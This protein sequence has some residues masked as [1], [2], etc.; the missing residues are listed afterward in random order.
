MCVI[1]RILTQTTHTNRSSLLG[2]IVVV[3]LG[4]FFF[5]WGK[6]DQRGAHFYFA[7]LFA[8]PTYMPVCV[9]TRARECVC[10]CMCKVLVFRRLRFVR[11]HNTEEEEEDHKHHSEEEEEEEVCF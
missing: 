5:G 6:V 10:V 7:L 1:V 4:C 8:L 3:P 2:L 9:F 11:I